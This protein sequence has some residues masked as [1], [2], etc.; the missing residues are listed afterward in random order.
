MSRL[1]RQC[2]AAVAVS[3]FGSA[4]VGGRKKSARQTAAAKAIAHGTR[5]KPLKSVMPSLREDFLD[6]VGADRIRHQR[7]DAEDHDVEQALRAGA[8]VLREIRVHEDVDRREEERVADAVQH[9]DQDDE[10]RVIAGRTR[11]PRNAP[12]GRG[13]RSIIVARQ[14]SF[15][16]VAPRMN[17]VRIS[18]IWPM[19]ITGMI[20]LP[21]MP[22][23][24]VVHA[25]PRKTPVQLK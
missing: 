8:G 1:T 20:Q 12:R 14:P 19:L 4:F 22:T 24:P 16:S 25:V 13:C 11:K 23:P 15:F 5:N 18:A 10:S 7:A 6:Q 2:A 21:G 17:I 3:N 9:L